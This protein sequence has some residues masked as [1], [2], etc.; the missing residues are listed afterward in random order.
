VPALVVAAGLGLPCSFRSLSRMSRVSYERIGSGYSSVRRPDDRIARI[1]SSALRDAASVVNVGAGAGSY[2]PIDR[3]VVAVEPSAEMR[4]QRPS[5]AAR[6]VAG[7]AE[8]IP[9]RDREV[10]A[11]MALY[12]DFHWDDRRRGIDELRRVSR[13]RVVMLTVDRE[14]SAQYWLF[15][16]Y[17]P[18]ANRIFGSIRDISCCFP[19]QP[20]VTPV[21]IPADCTDGFVHAFWKRPRSLLEPTVHGPMA[22]FAVLRPEELDAGLAQLRAD[23]GSGQWSRR[24]AD[25]ESRDSLDLGHRLVTWEHPPG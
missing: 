24:N 22:A 19:T 13:Q 6:C 10:D 18:V 4:S 11:A 25:L 3:H 14:V 9:L 20:Q 5:D 15:R 2:E 17:F 23:L 12:T 21:A 1:V 8:Q 7:S 16:D